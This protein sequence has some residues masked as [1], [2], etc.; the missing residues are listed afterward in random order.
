VK[1]N[2]ALDGLM[3]FDMQG[4][5]VGV[6][7]TGAI[8]AIVVRIMKAFGCKVLAYDVIKNDKLLQEI[9]ELQ[10]VDLQQLFAESD[11]ISLH[12]PL[13]K[14][15]TKMIN[16]DAI[17]KMK[18]G[19]MIVNTSR[20]PLLDTKAVIKALKTKKIGSIGL[21]VYENEANLFFE[22]HSNDPVDDDM[23]GRLTSFPNVI[24]TGHQ[25]F[26]T[27]EALDNISKSTMQNIDDFLSQKDTNELTKTLK[28][29][30]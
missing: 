28:S 8:G 16:E 3:G 7:G 15:T 22:D 4:K 24:V 10:Y 29:S 13:N 30:L 27:K 25:A 14:E 6:V 9:P 5:T 23:I 17:S 19:V 1:N 26:F 21:D 20:G 2:F 11:I 18:D 12:A